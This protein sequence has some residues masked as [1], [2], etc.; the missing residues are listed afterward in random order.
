MWFTARFLYV[1]TYNMFQ[2]CAHTWILANMTV[3]FLMFGR[4]ALADTFYSIGVVMSLCQLFTVLELFHIA[5]G[6]D[7][8]WILPRL[9]QVVERNLL[10][11][12]I[13]MME[14]IQSKPVVCAQFFL[15]NILGLLRYPQELLCVMGSPSLNMLW[16]RYTLYVP[17]YILAAVTEGV[18]VYQ[19]VN[20]LEKAGRGRLQLPISSPNRV[21][22]LLKTYLIIL[23]VGATV[24]VWQLVKERQQRL[25]K[26]NKKLKK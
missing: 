14:E 22:I 10:L 13:V 2:F 19:A 15:W 11:F 4:D 16:N 5:D 6:I 24:T 12:T 9:F 1:F 25:E 18:T 23:A 26:W 3:R 7:K 20:H 8:S 17:T 21:P